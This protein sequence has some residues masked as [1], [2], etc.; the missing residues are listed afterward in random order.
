MLLAKFINVFV[1]AVVLPFV[2]ATPY[3]LDNG[4][5]AY[6]GISING[7]EHFLNI[8]FGKDTSGVKRFSP[9]GPFLFPPWTVYDASKTGM[10]CPQP[11]GGGAY[12]SKAL[13]QSENCLKLR[14]L[15]PAIM[16]LDRAKAHEKGIPVLVNI[17]QGMSF[18]FFVRGSGWKRMGM[19]KAKGK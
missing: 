16:D 11:L 13:N 17:Y 1:P 19:G 6:Q 10:I 5:V 9:P 12:V 3:V 15:R 18:V 7:V 8:S 14:V 4:R 2:R